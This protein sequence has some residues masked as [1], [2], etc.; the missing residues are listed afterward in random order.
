MSRDN[1]KGLLI[2]RLRDLYQAE[3]LL[4]KALPPMARAASAP[5]L[6][7]VLERHVVQT[8]NQSQRLD[9]IFRRLAVDPRGRRCRGMEGILA[10]AYE[11]LE[12]YSPG[13]VTDAALIAAGQRIEHYE[14]AAYECVRRYALLLGRPDIADF[15]QQSLDEE[16]DT[17]RR[18]AEIAA[19]DIDFQA[20]ADVGAEAIEQ[21][22]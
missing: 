10:E 17:N 16:E 1:L 9:K 12:P 4:V 11:V 14:I 18:L 15:A 22:S 19:H 3:H 2:E 8:V 21:A 6:R 5:A 7:N 20:L 13:S